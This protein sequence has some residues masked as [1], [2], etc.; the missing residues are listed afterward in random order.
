MLAAHITAILLFLLFCC[1]MA[2]S[3]NKAPPE[4]ALMSPKIKRDRIFVSLSEI[5]T[6]ASHDGKMYCIR[7]LQ[8]DKR[9]MNP[10][11]PIATKYI[12]HTE[13]EAKAD[14]ALFEWYHGH[15]VT[16]DGQPAK[17]SASSFN[18]AWLCKPRESP[19]WTDIIVFV[20]GGGK[21]ELSPNP[22]RQ[23]PS[24]DIDLSR[25]RERLYIESI[26]GFAEIELNE[27]SEGDSDSD[28]ETDDDVVTAPAVAAPP[29][30]VLKKKF[31]DLGPKNKK[32]FGIFLKDKMSQL[33]PFDNKSEVDEVVRR[34]FKPDGNA[35]DISD[36]LRTSLLKAW[37]ERQFTHFIT[38][39]TILKAAGMTRALIETYLGV[40]IGKRRMT[41]IG[42]HLAKYG[43][44]GFPT[45]RERSSLRGAATKYSTVKKFGLFLV[46][47]GVKTAAARE[48][49]SDQHQ[50]F[51]IADI[52]RKDSVDRLCT[53]FQAQ[54]NKMY[55]EKKRLD[56][57]VISTSAVHE[58]L[59]I[60]GHDDEQED[61]ADEMQVEGSAAT[62][63]RQTRNEFSTLGI[64]SMREIVQV[65]CPQII[66]SLAALDVNS[67][68]HGRQ[69]HMK[70]RSVLQTMLVDVTR[71]EAAIAER[72]ESGNEYL[73]P[74]P[75][76]PAPPLPSP[77]LPLPLPVEDVAA[78]TEAA[79]TAA[80][81]PPQQECLQVERSTVA[82]IRDQLSCAKLG[83][84]DTLA[85]SLRA[86]A[87]IKSRSGF[88]SAHHFKG[89]ADGSTPE[90]DT[91][92]AG[93]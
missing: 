12:Y 80:S 72:T 73:L 87:H 56:A 2:T 28:Y 93:D 3:S 64:G 23:K 30:H 1:W 78:A 50:A 14:K 20:E 82:T 52:K 13:E 86:E 81:V 49:W 9:N 91:I 15:R 24:S 58:A 35:E 83:I 57:L 84:L 19:A 36:Q 92:A 11:K 26:P 32:L 4:D 45:D 8:L 66:K 85:T 51:M 76:P 6:Q 67:E 25:R 63:T 90:N 42:F 5:R 79:A 40:R 41:A 38:Q 89:E 18:P 33:M 60:D 17:P 31:T 70:M 44:G 71:L 54:E 88:W 27:I 29:S 59:P 39:A 10:K 48:V 46:E 47:N 7:G 74:L 16:I 53:D 65:V 62:P 22:K 75:L 68:V 21:L 69:C 61:E 34:I 55:A 77:P 37:N 43:A